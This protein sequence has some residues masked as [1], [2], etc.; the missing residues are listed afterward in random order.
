MAE[1]AGYIGSNVPP[2][3]WG[4]ITRDYTDRLIQLNEQRK[5]EQEKIDDMEAEAYAKVGD[6]QS[7][8]SQPF[9]SF[10]ADTVDANKQAIAM[11]AKLVSQ[12]LLSRKEFKKA[13]L[14]ATTNTN[15]LNRFATT[16][17]S[18]ADMLTKAASE[19]KLGKYGSRMAE[20]FG[21]FQ[22]TKSRK[23]MVDPDTMGLF[24]ADVDPE[25]KTIK[26]KDNISSVM[27]LSNPANYY[28][29]KVD[30][31]SSIKGIKERLGKAGVLVYNQ[32]GSSYVS[33]SPEN[34]PEYEKIVNSNA[35]ALASTPNDVVN[36]L[37]DYAGYDTYSTPEEK[38]ARIAEGSDPKK[39]IF[40][41]QQ[42][43]LFVPVL[44]DAQKAEATKIV[45]DNIE[46]SLSNEIS[47]RQAAPKGEKPTDAETKR[48]YL[49]QLGKEITADV[50]NPESRGLA[51]NSQRVVAQAA[52]LLGFKNATI[53]KEFNPA[54]GSY[55]KINIYRDG[56]TFE[57][58]NKRP[59]APPA[60]TLGGER[61]ITEFIGIDPQDAT[62]G[63]V[64]YQQAVEES[65]A[66]PKQKQNKGLTPGSL[67]N[68]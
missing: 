5:G 44:T 41:K 50:S 42:E 49:L 7:T 13:L 38:E 20:R 3:D 65:G 9:N 59:S 35:S 67:N 45:K 1:F 22:Y 10:M 24:I 64:K 63:Y 6:I 43:N 15:V 37:S 26:S 30:L 12:G 27:T 48:K 51:D 61:Q 32:D 18:Q 23:S 57:G 34:K 68:L 47:G 21:S 28:I 29:P 52:G 19:G 14:T 17:Q 40:L 11:K 54:T 16:Y 60:I 4:K 58:D 46:A 56:T 62:S 55:D 66:L 25:T 2:T 36:I 31:D 53:R 33:T 8:S 39:L